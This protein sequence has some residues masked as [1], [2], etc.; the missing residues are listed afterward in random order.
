M[1]APAPMTRATHR[2][3]RPATPICPPSHRQRITEKSSTYSLVRHTRNNE[4]MSQ[5]R[6]GSARR[7]ATS[8][9]PEAFAG[10]LESCQVHS[11]IEILANLRV[12]IDER[13][14]AAVYFDQDTKF[15]LT[16]FLNINPQ[17]E[18]LIFDLG[19]DPRVNEK[20]GA[21]TEL[22][23]VALVEHIKIQFS[24]GRAELTQFEGAPALRVRAPRSI[25]RLQR[26]AAFRARTQTSSSPYLLLP[27]APDDFGD[28]EP[29]RV[30]V[31][32]ISATG[33]AVVAP[34][35]KPALKPGLL[36]LRCLLELE[37]HASFAV[38]IEIRHVSIFKDGTGREMCRAGCHLQNLSGAME[39]L[40]QRYVNQMGVSGVGKR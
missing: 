6:D 28:A 25:L 26:R 5:P 37:A 40:I 21:S 12:L 23:V 22:T 32:D 9:L 1:I 20:L 16:R 31:A 18:E 33:C 2:T 24:V 17:F 35:G 7:P 8:L 30:K 34:A 10:A 19:P 15:I 27:P 11:P 3:I 13:V 14:M 39:M 29:A 36:L 4:R 38:D